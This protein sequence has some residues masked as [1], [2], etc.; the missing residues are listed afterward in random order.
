M[1]SGLNFY[2]FVVEVYKNIIKDNV[3]D[4]I[5]LFN[6]MALFIKCKKFKFTKTLS[7]ILSV[8]NF[9][10]GYFHN[11]SFASDPL[12]RGPKG[13]CFANFCNGF[14]MPCINKVY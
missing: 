13:K 4:F 6:L 9:V 3:I 14:S 7:R 2:I 12:G 5:I 1:V 11:A 8:K 10:F